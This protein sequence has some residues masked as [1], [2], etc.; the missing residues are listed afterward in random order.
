MPTAAGGGGQGAANGVNGSAGPGGSAGAGGAG[1]VPGAGDV[2]DGSDEAG[3]VL[4]SGTVARPEDAPGTGTPGSAKDD[5]APAPASDEGATG[6]AAADARPAD[7]ATAATPALTRGEGAD[8]ASVGSP[9]A[10]SA[11]GVTPAP[12]PVEGADAPASG[13]NPVPASDEGAHAPVVGS[14]TA[15][16]AGGGTAA[17]APGSGADA[18]GVGS[19]APA[20]GGDADGEL[21]PIMGPRE[22]RRE[23]WRRLARRPYALAGVA[24]LFVVASVCGLAAP[25]L[26]G[27]I[28]AAVSEGKSTSF[29]VGAAVGIVVA[30]VVAALVG[31]FAHA[32]L[33][34]LFQSALADLREEAFGT[35]LGL[36]QA[37][38]EKA[39]V[40]DVVSRVSGDVEAVGEAVGGVLPA[41]T[42]SAFTI[43][44]TAA[45]LAVLDPR[46][47]LGALVAVPIQ[48]WVTRWFLARSGPVYRRL[49]V[50]EGQRTGELVEV[51]S[52]EDTIVG[53][54][55]SARHSRRVAAAS[56]AA[57]VPGLEAT[58]LRAGFYNGLNGAEFVGL[59]SVLAVGAWLT[60]S[61]SVSISAATTAAL[62][63]FRLFDPIGIVLAELDALQR[64]MA[65]LSRLFGVVGIRETTAVPRATRRQREARRAGVP[66]RLS[67]EDVTFSYQPDRPAVRGV[68]LTVEP[69]ERVAVVGASGSGKSS[70]AGLVAGIHAPGSGRV[71]LDGD[72]VV[73]GAA[74]EAGVLLVTQ[75]V[76]V[77]SGTVA[78]NLRLA[79]PDAAPDALAAALRAVGA[80]WVFALEDGADTRVGPEALPLTNE[81]AQQLALAR[82]VLA[83]PRVVVLDEATAE[84]GARAAR[85]LD[86][87]TAE[88]IGG[89]SAL[90]IA[91]R[92]TQAVG[93][94]RVVVMAEGRVV[95]SGPHDAL[96]AAGGAY[97]RLW[98]AWSRRA[99]TG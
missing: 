88:A 27:Q 82:V 75:E 93:A 40:G 65:G 91:H 80:E 78:D 28:V 55:R 64:A 22:A 32:V 59:A 50:A 53:T 16:P 72:P 37:R 3:V 76:R 94:D 62:L 77:F 36:P 86:R 46:F 15:A 34:R 54:G 60:S 45:G 42:A 18:A 12:A 85:A 47:A 9:T 6:S 70:L 57:I 92:L 30:G 26:L 97:A 73:P 48:V 99:V 74:A 4:P 5:A 84:T 79:A 52:S 21:L 90:V 49:R 87:A 2:S 1:P 29:V 14:P 71:L 98:R 35:A 56:E 81:Q 25:A 39:G 61:D 69:G 20:G 17:P 24:L 31:R 43:V 8:V 11:G 51:F 66:A 41:L 58:R 95:E 33:A 44:A 67:I 19:S 38:L 96:L 63:Y 10:A 23:A 13:G 89:S 83:R 68:S 7:S